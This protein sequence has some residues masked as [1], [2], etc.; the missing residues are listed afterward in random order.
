MA[1]IDE[2][3]EFMA[4]FAELKSRVDDDPGQLIER[5]EQDQRLQEIC[6]RLHE[7]ERSLEVAEEWSPVALT[8]HVSVASAKSRRDYQERWSRQVNFVASRWA[9]KILDS[10]IPDTGS[11]R[12][13][14][15]PDE[16]SIEI[17]NWKYE[18][19]KERALL[20]QAFDYL[21]M[22]QENDDDGYL[23]W[24]IEA[25][26]AWT[27]LTK[28]AG[29]DIEG[30]LWRRRAIPH[31]LVPTHVANRYG[32]KRASLYRRLHQAGRAFVF[33]A[34]LAALALQRAALEE[35]LR[36]HWG[37]EKGHLRE[38]KL[39]DLGWDRMAHKLKRLA[40]E[41]LHEDPEKLTPE[42]LD[43]AVIENF[44]LLRVLVEN[45][46]PDAG[47]HQRNSQ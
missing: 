34:P 33:G 19:G 9:H 32:Q 2:G 41:A 13:Q 17:E 8:P 40:N 43:R 37:A 16:L 20:E 24:A 5:W 47:E 15:R 29:L 3:A 7:L 38:A 46:P 1:E 39:P 14:R 12:F 4:G 11:P 22:R 23:D 6:D 26:W 31:I 21:R 10:L 27:R 28:V 45:A 36:K 44:I 30:A 35:L 25:N 42:Q 18:A